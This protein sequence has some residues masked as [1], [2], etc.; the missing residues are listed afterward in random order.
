[1]WK[2]NKFSELFILALLA[3]LCGSVL[4]KT[5]FKLDSVGVFYINT[6]LNA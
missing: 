4:N 3:F 5:V 2:Q 6:I 1:M